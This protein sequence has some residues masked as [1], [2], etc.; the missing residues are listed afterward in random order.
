VEAAPILRRDLRRVDFS[1]GIPSPID[2][3]ESLSYMGFSLQIFEFKGF[4]GKF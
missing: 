2:L 4:I 3:L 1:V